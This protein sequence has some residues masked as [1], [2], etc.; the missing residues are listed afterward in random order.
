MTSSLFVLK[1]TLTA[2]VL[3]AF[4][5]IRVNFV[6]N[7]PFH[8]LVKSAMSLNIC[9]LTEQVG[10][11][12]FLPE[13]VSSSGGNYDVALQQLLLQPSNPYYNDKSFHELSQQETTV[14]ST[15]I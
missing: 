5:I 3:P 2:T 12:T 15:N 10:C 6:C 9:N 13:V 14:Q 4:A 1:I 7:L 11:L 8:R